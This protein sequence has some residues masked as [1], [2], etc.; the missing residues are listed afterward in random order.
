M[1]GKTSKE[2]GDSGLPGNGS[3]PCDVRAGNTKGGNWRAR[4]EQRIHVENKISSD[5]KC[6]SGS[7]RKSPT[8]TTGVY[9]QKTGISYPAPSN[10]SSGTAQFLWQA[11]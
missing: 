4:F 6:Q 10:S 1:V 9:R 3:Q 7:R 11:L 2:L 8:G 5:G